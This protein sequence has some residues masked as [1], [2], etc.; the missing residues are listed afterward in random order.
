MGRQ[1]QKESEQS[2]QEAYLEVERRG[3]GLAFGQKVC[4]PGKI[5]VPNAKPFFI[6]NITINT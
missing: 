4:N 2:F 1:F 5:N 6:G 3:R